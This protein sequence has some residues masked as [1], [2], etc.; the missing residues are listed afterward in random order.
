MSKEQ[1]GEKQPTEKREDEQTLDCR[2]AAVI[3][4][5]GLIRPI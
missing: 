4:S 2:R 3:G 5:I 1:A